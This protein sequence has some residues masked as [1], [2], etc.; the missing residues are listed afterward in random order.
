MNINLSEKKKKKNNEVKSNLIM[1]ILVQ[2]DPKFRS[3]MKSVEYVKKNE[4]K[5]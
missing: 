1:D 3:V 5:D 2:K 4:I